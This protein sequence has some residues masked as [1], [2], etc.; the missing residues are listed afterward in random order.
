MEPQNWTIGK[1]VDISDSEYGK[2]FRVFLN[3]YNDEVSGFTKWPEKI[4]EGAEIYGHIE[5][6]GKYRNFKFDKKAESSRPTG[7]GGFTDF[8]REMLKVVY[9]YVMAQG[10]K[11]YPER[12]ETNDMHPLDEGINPEDVPF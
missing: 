6:K 11:P 4:V 1:V 8:D 3:G 7:G 12:N 10:K 9:N 2:R 5:L